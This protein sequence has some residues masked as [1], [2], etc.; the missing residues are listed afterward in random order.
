[1]GINGTDKI[2]Q[3]NNSYSPN[4]IF[5]PGIKFSHTSTHKTGKLQNH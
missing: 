4:K 3:L 2:S 5:Y 1:M